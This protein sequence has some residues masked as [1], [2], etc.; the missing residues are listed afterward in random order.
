MQ[1]LPVI[2][3]VH[4]NPRVTPVSSINP[5]D[6][7]QPHTVPTCLLEK[8]EVLENLCPALFMGF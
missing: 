3:S 8:A 4:L 7:Y 2:I 6:R 5:C 1:Q